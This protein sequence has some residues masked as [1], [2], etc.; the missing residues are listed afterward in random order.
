M[1]G[2]E[3]NCAQAGWADYKMRPWFEEG[4]QHLAKDSCGLQKVPW[5][6]VSDTMPLRLLNPPNALHPSSVIPFVH[7]LKLQLNRGPA[8]SVPLGQAVD[9][10]VWLGQNQGSSDR[11]ARITWN[12]TLE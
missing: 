2:S 7:A 9:T 1:W 10:T 8:L 3:W 5:R 6:E 11:W 12:G 4:Q